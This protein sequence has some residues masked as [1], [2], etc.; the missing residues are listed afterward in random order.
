MQCWHACV[1]MYVHYEHEPFCLKVMNFT[2]C[3]LVDTHSSAVLVYI[4][5]ILIGMLQRIKQTV[6]TN[7]RT[8]IYI[9]IYIYVADSCV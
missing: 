4:A 5:C 1:H 9:Y 7:I 3:Q 8:H 2:V 6:G